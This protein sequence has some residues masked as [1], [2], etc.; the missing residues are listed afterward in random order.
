[1]KHRAADGNDVI[2]AR[3]PR[4]GVFPAFILSCMILGPGLLNPQYAL[5]WFT[6][7]FCVSVIGFRMLQLRLEVT[8]DDVIVTNF[9]RTIA[10]PLTE[11]VVEPNQP[12]VG[13]LELRDG[14][15]ST[16]HVGAAPSWAVNLESLRQRLI[17]EIARHG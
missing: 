8:D 12:Q 4:K 16:I 6:G 1:M 15:G 10:V 2:I 13:Y 5:A 14:R 11:V 3:L 9:F 17:E 7:L